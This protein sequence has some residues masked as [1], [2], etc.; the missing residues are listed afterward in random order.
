MNL[1]MSMR[2]E[3]RLLLGMSCTVCGTCPGEGESHA[4]DTTII[5]VKEAISSQPSDAVFNTCPKCG[6]AVRCSFVIIQNVQTKRYGFRH[7]AKV[8]SAQIVDKG[9]YSRWAAKERV[10]TL[11][12][13]E[14]RE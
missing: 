6:H 11:N 13:G 8:R 12:Q 1:G 9:P 3:P 10:K 14:A 5:K 2:L 4:G 7:E